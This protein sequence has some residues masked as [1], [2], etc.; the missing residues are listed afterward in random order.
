MEEQ[1]FHQTS[2]R[3][4]F[5]K[6]L[7][8]DYHKHELPILRY[9]AIPHYAINKKKR[10]IQAEG[11]KEKEKGE[12]KV[13]IAESHDSP[14]KTSC[15]DTYSIGF[16]TRAAAASITFQRQ[17]RRRI[18]LSL[19]CSEDAHFDE[20]RVE[21]KVRPDRA[22]LRFEEARRLSVHIAVD[23]N[24]ESS[25]Y[26]TDFFGLDYISMRL[27]AKHNHQRDPRCCL[28]S[29]HTLIHRHS[30]SHTGKRLAMN[31]K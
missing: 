7:T 21:V 10:K 6:L 23:S 5:M 8:I 27:R 11:S 29:I 28:A 12:A 2:G 3:V 25:N 31:W 16:P 1:K 14:S 24:L 22:Q 4:V 13:P 15:A 19:G 17:S 9:S 26:V 18:D 30:I 20:R